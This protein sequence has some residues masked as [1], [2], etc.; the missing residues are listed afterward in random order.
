MSLLQGKGEIFTWFLTGED[1]AQR[2]RR[3]SQDI[4]REDGSCLLS[5]L[6]PS[7]RDQVEIRR[8]SSTSSTLSLPKEE[9]SMVRQQS[10][11]YE[12]DTH[13]LMPNGH[14]SE[15]SRR[16]LSDTDIYVDTPV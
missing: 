12:E 13:V 4:P 7:V 1:K 5:R 16:L 9:H 14:A 11:P 6:S 8:I 10:T 3:I 2:L 15:S